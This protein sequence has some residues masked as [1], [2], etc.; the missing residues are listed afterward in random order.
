MILGSAVGMKYILRIRLKLI[1]NTW[2]DKGKSYRVIFKK[3]DSTLPIYCFNFQMISCY[4]FTTLHSC[5]YY[6]S[7]EFYLMKI[8]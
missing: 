7:G 3:I 8:D 2:A 5:T 4:I 1:G 6:L